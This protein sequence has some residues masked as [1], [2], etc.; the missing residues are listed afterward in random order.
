MVNPGT[1]G[2]PAALV[3]P[4]TTLGRK[5]RLAIALTAREILE[6]QDFWT[7]GVAPIKSYS[8]LGYSESRD[9]HR[10][11]LGKRLGKGWLAENAAG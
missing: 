10:T 9:L 8:E 7:E 5:L 3:L 11:A 1:A 4:T 2:F 6:L